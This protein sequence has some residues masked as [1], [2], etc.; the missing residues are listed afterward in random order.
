MVSDVVT[1]RVSLL[2]GNTDETH[3]QT[4]RLPITA[5]E[6]EFGGRNDHFYAWEGAPPGV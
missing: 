5:G 3:R 4:D 1:Q 2:N 6:G